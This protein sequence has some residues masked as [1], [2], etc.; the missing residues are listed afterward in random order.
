MINVLVV[1]DEMPA[2]ERL[3]RLLGDLE[4]E[5]FHAAGSVENGQ[6]AVEFCKQQEVDIVLMDIRMPQMDGLQAAKLIAEEATQERPAP[7]VIFTTAFGEYALDAFEAQGTGY[8]LKPV[9][10]QNLLESLQKAQQINRAQVQAA[11]N[12]TDRSE[13]TRFISGS[14]RGATIREPLHNII[15]FQAEQK[16]V[17]AYGKEKQILM[18]ETLKSLEERYG[19]LFVRIHRNALVAKN[20]IVGISRSDG[21]P[22]LMLR[23]TEEQLEISRRHLADIKNLVTSRENII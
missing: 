13:E 17:M 10:K 2:R 6:Q 4:Q 23:D 12:Q 15:Y 8:L 18:D 22:R 1:D 16:Y 21:Q 14:F 19:E 20:S 9:R 7:A 3:L 5:D 11:T